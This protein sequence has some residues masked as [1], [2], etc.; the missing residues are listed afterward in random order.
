ML[1]SADPEQQLNSQVNANDISA[2]DVG[3]IYQEVGDVVGDVNPDLLDAAENHY[4]QQPDADGSYA[5]DLCSDSNQP[6]AAQH[7]QQSEEDSAIYN[8]LRHFEP[9][10][11]QH[12]EDYS[13]TSEVAS[14]SQ[15]N[16]KQ[17]DAEVDITVG[18]ENA[19]AIYAV[20]NK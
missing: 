8:K 19:A 15:L 10:V 18:D 5:Y 3:E 2:G 12:N 6:S 9:E 11:P 7:F 20:V 13:T 14:T 17:Y 1:C 4:Y 16:N